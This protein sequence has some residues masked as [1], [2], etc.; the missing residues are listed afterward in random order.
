MTLETTAAVG[1]AT[2]GGAGWNRSHPEAT[3]ITG[4]N[5]ANVG[6]AVFKRRMAIPFLSI[7]LT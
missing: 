5:R 6:T 2:G 1:A 3:R 7:S 4:S